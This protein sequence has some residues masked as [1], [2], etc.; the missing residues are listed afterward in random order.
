MTNALGRLITALE[1]VCKSHEQLVEAESSQ[2]DVEVL[3]GWDTENDGFQ[4]DSNLEN[5]IKCRK[6][7]RVFF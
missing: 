1:H 7:F 2:Q 5:V 6:M 4:Q 3:S